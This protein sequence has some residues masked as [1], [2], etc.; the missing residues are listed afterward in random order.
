M[1]YSNACDAQAVGIDANIEGGCEPPPGMFPCGAIFCLSGMDY[2]ERVVSDVVGVPDSYHCKPATDPCGNEPVDCTCLAKA[3]CGEICEMT[4]EGYT[5]T[6][7]G[8]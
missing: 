8:G 7:P 2:C 1:V 4:G 5:V 6:C 3:P